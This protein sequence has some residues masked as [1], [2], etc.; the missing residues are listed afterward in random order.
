MRLRFCLALLSAGAATALAGCD[1]NQLYLGSRTVVGINASVN[2]EVSS[3]SLI[4]GYDRT[5]ATV[6]P[7]TAP[8]IPAGQSGQPEPSN[9]TGQK[10]EAM[11]AIAC[12]SL[13]V[14]GITIRRFTESIAT[15]EAARLFARALKAD[16]DRKSVKDFFDC[17]KDKPEAPGTVEILREAT[18]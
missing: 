8:V 9:Q 17:F 10:Q 7:R 1:A 13:Q 16:A 3:G 5:F 6:I 14:N 4:V 2:P 18:R 12:S 11:A 15:G